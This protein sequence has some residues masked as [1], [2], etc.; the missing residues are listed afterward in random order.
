[1]KTLK[2]MVAET[3]DLVERLGRERDARAEA[4]AI[5][6]DF[7]P[8][9]T[10]VPA[11]LSFVRSSGRTEDAHV[12]DAGIASLHRRDGFYN[13]AFERDRPSDLG[14][15]IEFAHAARKAPQ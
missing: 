3:S 11:P 15:I 4:V 9:P 7:D 14:N 1:M 13:L 8:E 6:D 5:G 12:V 10:D 2:Q